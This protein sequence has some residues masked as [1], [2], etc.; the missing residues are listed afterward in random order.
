[1]STDRRA[2][3][4]RAGEDATASLYRA[5]GFDVV[6]RNWRCDLGEVD[7]V[8]RRDGLL[9]FCEVKTRS[10]DRYGGGFDAVTS[11]KRAKLRRLAAVYLLHE[12]PAETAV[13]FDVASV[14]VSGTRV[15]IELYEDAF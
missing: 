9:V 14:L 4:G 3:T 2:A 11:V 1:V 10:G 13:R 8:A 12:R 6:A 7:L 5:R 15:D